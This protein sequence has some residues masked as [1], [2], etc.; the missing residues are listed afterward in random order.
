MAAPTFFRSGESRGE[1]KL[2]TGE[3]KFYLDT[4]GWGFIKPHDK[5]E[6]DLF[7]HIRNSGPKWQPEIGDVVR[8]RVDTSPRNGKPEARDVCLVK[9]NSGTSNKPDGAQALAWEARQH[10]G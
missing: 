5:S 3:I 7:F 2:V 9:P 4:K 10:D 8:Y 1:N 6:A